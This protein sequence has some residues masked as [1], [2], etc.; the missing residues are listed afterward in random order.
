MAVTQA[1]STMEVD[2]D[3]KRDEAADPTGE[4]TAERKA[5]E[6]LAASTA[7]A[8]QAGGGGSS[9]LQPGAPQQDDDPTAFYGPGQETLKRAKGSQGAD[10]SEEEWAEWEKQK[11]SRMAEKA[12]R[13]EDFKKKLKQYGLDVASHRGPGDKASPY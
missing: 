12:K 4:F 9:S 1:E 6:A 5:E 2:K 3:L 10:W 7:G 13:A 8:S 11:D